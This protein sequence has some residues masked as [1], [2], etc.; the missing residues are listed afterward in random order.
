MKAFVKDINAIL[1]MRLKQIHRI[2]AQLAIVRLLILLIACL[3]LLITVYVTSKGLQNAILLSCIWMLIIVFIHAKRSDRIFLNINMEFDKLIYGV[4]YIVL[5]IPLIIC[6]LLR[7]QWLT[8]ICLVICILGISSLKINQNKQ[9]KTLNTHLQ[10][11]I[12]YG[13]YE[14]KAGIRQYFFPIA[15]TWLLGLIMAFFF[16]SVPVA[17]FIIGLLIFDFYKINESWQILLSCQRNA[18]K[19]LYFKIKQHVTLFSIITLPLIVAFMIFHFENWYIVVAEFV[20]L[21]S[22]HIYAIL[23]KYAFYSHD[24]NEVNPVFLMVGLF[25]GLIPI[26]TL[27]L[28]LLSMYIFCKAKKNLIFYLNDYN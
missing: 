10:Q 24:R 23:L 20:I 4:E 5:S 12:P 21:L 16:A 6:L 22:V 19:F 2:I 13:M 3:Y 28:W 11:L 14:W 27:V 18:D 25:I 17:L 8:I 26:T 15:I 7:R 1:L 9:R